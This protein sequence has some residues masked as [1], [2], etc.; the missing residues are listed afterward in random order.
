M[1]LKHIGEWMM[2]IIK[3]S[4]LAKGFDVCHAGMGR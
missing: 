4:H 2:E 3:R 1:T